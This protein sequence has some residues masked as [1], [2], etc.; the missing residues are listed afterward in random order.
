[1]YYSYIKLNEATVQN[2]STDAMDSGE[3]KTVK[4]SSAGDL[5]K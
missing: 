3:P 4:L 5:G 1:M 2:A